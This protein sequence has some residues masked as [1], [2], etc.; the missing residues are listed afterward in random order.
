MGDVAQEF[1]EAT[2][3][4]QD[5]Y[6]G[7]KSSLRNKLDPLYARLKPGTD[8]VHGQQFK[9]SVQVE[10]PQ[11]VGNTLTATQVLPEAEPGEY[12][13]L[14]LKPVRTYGTLLFDRM[15]LLAAGQNAD[16][17]RTYVNYLENE[18]KGLKD[19]MAKEISRQLYGNKKGF[20]ST[21]G[22]TAAATTLV[23]ATTAKMH[24][25]AKRGHIDIVTTATGVAIANG[26]NR[27]IQSV[28]VA[29]KTMVLDAAGGVVTT[30]NTMSIVRKGAYNA[31][32]TGLADINSA[33]VDIYGIITAAQRRW[34]AYVAAAMG[35]FDIKKVIKIGLDAGVEG[36]GDPN[37][38]ISCPDLQAQYWYQLTGTRTVDANNPAVPAKKLSTGYYELSVV[39]NGVECKWIASNN[40]PS[41]EIHALCTEDLG[42]QHLAEPAFMNI[43]GQIL[44]PNVYGTTGTPTNK[45][46]IE[47]YWQMICTRR[48]SHI[49]MPGVTDIAG[50]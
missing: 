8:K 24:Q 34:Q 18:M 14:A 12:I 25:F 41:G 49:Y 44:L 39:M 23:L 38:L 5:M 36:G 43:N 50:W 42:L 32:A 17:K 37:L 6:G 21:C 35:P 9:F 20:I 10:Q 4:L 28:N 46:V 48:N 30:D 19:Y 7:F 22:V 40:C 33:T 11:G 15:M 27:I 45:A 13:E 1:T 47:Y 16:G 3:I 29:A 31:E 2:G 26:S